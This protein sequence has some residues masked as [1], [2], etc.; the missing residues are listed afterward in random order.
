MKPKSTPLPFLALAGSSLM[1]ISSVSAQAVN[2]TWNVDT[3]GNWSLPDNW[4]GSPDPVP[5][6]VGSIINFTNDIT[7]NRIV[8]VDTTS[9]TVGQLTIGDS[10]NT[11]Y[12]TLAASGGAGLIFNNN[13][14]G[15]TLTS[16][17]T[18]AGLTA[19]ARDTI[20]APITLADNLTIDVAGAITGGVPQGGHFAIIGNIDESGGAR[21]ITKNGN[22]SLILNGNNSYSG[23]FTL[24]EGTVQVGSSGG[25]LGLFTGFGTGTLTINGG[26]IG[27]RTAASFT[28]ENDSI[29]I[30]NFALYRG[31]TGQ[32]TWNHEGDVTLGANITHTVPNNSFILNV[33]G[34]IG[35]TG[36]ARSL[37]LNSGNL[38]MTLSGNNTYSGGT[39]LTSGTLRINSATALGSGVLN[40]NG[41]TIDNTSGS[42]VTLSTN[43]VI[44]LGGTVAFSGSNDL[45]L[46]NGDTS[47]AGARTIT[48]NGTN[49]TLTL[50]G[51]LTN[52][53]NN[54]NNL[55]VNGAGNTLVLGGLALS[56]NNTNRTVEF[57][58]TGNVLITGAV[59]NGGA[60][61]VGSLTKGSAVAHTGTL[62]LAG[63]NTYAGTTI[64]NYGTMQLG[65]GG[66]T[67][68]LTG[69]SSIAVNNDANLTINRSNAF[70]QATDLN[71]KAIT[72]TGSFT[73]SGSGTTTLS[74]ENTYTGDTTV[75]AGT[76][77][78]NGSIASSR[79]T[80][81]ASGATISGSGTIGALTISTGGF[82]NP[83]N[84]PGILNT[85]N[86]IQSGLYTAEIGGLIP[87]NQHD[88]I[89]VTGTVDITGGS[90]SL[91]FSGTYNLGDMMFL[92]LNDGNDAITGVFNGFADGSTVSTYGGYNWNISYF[93]DSGTNA[94][95]GGNDIAIRAEA[96]P[97]PKAAL[98]G[99]LGILL[100]FRRR[101]WNSEP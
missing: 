62:T 46:G 63:T 54:N 49:S 21:S 81:V 96:I 17:N 11:H 86:Y 2:G 73:Q 38:T 85:G 76:L 33:S 55:T 87:G 89:N 44:T 82:I 31:Q 57:R 37:T 75:S 64:V 5:G 47:F 95:I 10:N 90:L 93:A 45:N 1:A 51:V 88:Q 36:G 30:A 32:V 26:T 41:G 94:F 4:L 14:N 42:A 24:N 71:G 50:G 68:S 16:T 19:S 27:T 60:S 65:N 18:T 39:T 77:V 91:L 83:G 100:L 101:R 35:E 43:N 61:N 3:A 99:G 53:Q 79:L 56:S 13:G 58:G 74:L 8:T 29:W 9:R 12:F 78:V 92:L 22:G 67:G 72:G 25:D 15:A 69:T 52:T 66:T 34:N 20:S 28:T 6:G 80:T 23:G 97:E 84:S 98:L 7:N 48:L 59:V 70:T 40:L